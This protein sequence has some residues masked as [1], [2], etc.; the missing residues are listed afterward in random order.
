MIRLCKYVRQIEIIRN[1]NSI[2]YIIP[3][4]T[5]GKYDTYATESLGK[6]QSVVVKSDSV[7]ISFEILKEEKSPA[8]KA[9]NIS[10]Q[11]V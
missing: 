11:D 7:E 3:L 4:N 10:N 8:L 2:Q 6:Q 9:E 5:Y 1:L